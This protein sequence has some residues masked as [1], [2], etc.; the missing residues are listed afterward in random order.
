MPNWCNYILFFT[1]SKVKER[2]L[3]QFFTDLAKKEQKEDK[4]QL[5][6]FCNSEVGFLFFIRWENGILYY[7]TRW[8]PNI[9]VLVE[10][11]EHFV[12]DFTYKYSEL[13]MQIYGECTFTKGVLKDY[14]LDAE[15][16]EQFDVN[17]DDEDTYLF[18]GSVYDSEFEIVDI[19][20]A[21]KKTN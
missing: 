12:V 10:I 8:S 3:K 20:L 21:R 1:C 4:G 9:E 6:E 2:K 14:S 19:L 11:A 17:P 13:M 7:D 5:P 16:F 15:D 18:E